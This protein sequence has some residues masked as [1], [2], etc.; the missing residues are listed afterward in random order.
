MGEW[1]DRFLSTPLSE[2]EWHWFLLVVI[3]GGV[4]TIA[5]VVGGIYLV[6]FLVMWFWETM[7]AAFLEMVGDVREW[8]SRRTAATFDDVHIEED[9]DQPS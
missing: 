4:I 7:S 9:D 6:G 8:F 3:G 1:L 5:L 2:L